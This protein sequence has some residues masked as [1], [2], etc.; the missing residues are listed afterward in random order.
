M[1][2][3]PRSMAAAAPAAAAADRQ[4]VWDLPLRVSHWGLA[5][6]VTGS[7]V[8]H[9][10]GPAAFGWHVWCG[11]WT[12]TLVA[13]RLLWGLIGPRYARFA[14]FMRGPRA[15]RAALNSLRAGR[16]RPAAGHTPPGGWMILLLLALLLAQAL[17]GL[18]ANDEILNSGPLAGY[19]RH[20]T[21]NRLSVWHGY[22]S[23]AILVA[24][25]LHVAAAAYYWRALGDNLVAPLISG[26]KRGL[27]QGSA[28]GSQRLVL[29]LV[30]LLAAAALL[31]WIVCSAPEPPE[32]PL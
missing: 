17:T 24:V 25:A 8:S 6:G 13:F 3:E 23:D 11:Y 4:L 32:L 12:L 2:K 1:A 21:S 14:S 29:A 15:V 20:A 27:P 28:I 16:H 18:F 19:V 10:I 26:Y 7:F 9:Y 22:L 31:A 5:L 30:T